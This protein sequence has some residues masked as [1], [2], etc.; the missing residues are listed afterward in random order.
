MGK[1]LHGG[2]RVQTDKRTQLFTG[3]QEFGRA[4]VPAAKLGR[5]VEGRQPLRVG[6]QV[7]ETVAGM[8]GFGV[9][10]PSGFLLGALSQKCRADLLAIDPGQL[11]ATERQSCGRQQQEEFLEIDTLDRTLDDK[12]CARL[13]HV[14]D[15][16]TA[17]PCA[18]NGHEPDRET[19]LER[20]AASIWFFRGHRRFLG[21]GDFKLDGGNGW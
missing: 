19:A 3:Q 1:I 17:A 13:G 16:A 15:A 6:C 20:D 12:A 10:R 18:V 14:H 7:P 11:A 2:S 8:S 9:S 21:A 5:S 4:N